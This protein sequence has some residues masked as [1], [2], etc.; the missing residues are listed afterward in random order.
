MTN[1]FSDLNNE[2]KTRLNEKTIWMLQQ[3]RRANAA[4]IG[5]IEVLNEHSC[6]EPSIPAGPGVFTRLE[7]HQEMGL[8]YAIEACSRDIAR[9]FDNDLEELG[10]N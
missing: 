9:I 8:H 5:C 1:H 6:N 4:I 3:A 10:V 7:A 2:P